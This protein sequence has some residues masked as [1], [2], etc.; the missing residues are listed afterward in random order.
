EIVGIIRLVLVPE[1]CDGGFGH[2]TQSSAMDDTV[3]L[4]SIYAYVSPRVAPRLR[5][6]A[7]GI[8][9]IRY[10]FHA[11]VVLA[12]ATLLPAQEPL[13]QISGGPGKPLSTAEAQ[14]LFKLPP[15]LRIELVAAEPQIESPVAMAFAPDGKLWVVEMKDYPN[16]PAK[17]QPPE[18]RIKIL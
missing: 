6:L 10:T 5:R 1:K 3:S 4:P 11:L 16:G 7:V 8:A 12:A 17:G 2:R 9:M 18:G 15:G 14:K 13:K